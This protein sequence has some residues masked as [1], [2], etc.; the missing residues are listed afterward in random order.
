MS[1]A[2]HR[3]PP[4]FS[5]SSASSPGRDRT[6]PFN[7]ES[8]ITTTSLSSFP[9]F[10]TRFL[11]SYYPAHPPSC[12]LLRVVCLSNERNGFR[13]SI[14]GGADLQGRLLTDRV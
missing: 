6:L 9:P 10:P 4:S 14:N 1:I 5:F 11:S 3:V 12:S 13:E 2:K 8:R 7:F